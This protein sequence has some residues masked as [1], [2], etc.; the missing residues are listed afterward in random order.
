MTET[1][2]SRPRV[3]WCDKHQR[4][5]LLNLDMTDGSHVPARYP[6]PCND[7]QRGFNCGY[8]AAVE[9]MKVSGEEA[10]R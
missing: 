10:K 1:P 6:E 3:I 7:F 5:E 4:L 2:S 8:D 9:S